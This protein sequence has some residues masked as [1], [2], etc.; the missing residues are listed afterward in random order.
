MRRFRKGTVTKEDIQNINTRYIL[1]PDV[2]SPS[3][4]HTRYACYRNVE[5]NEYNNFTRQK[6][7]EGTHIKSNY[8]SVNFPLHTCIIKAAMKYKDKRRSHIDLTI[9]NRILDE[10]DDSDIINSKQSFVD[11]SLKF[12]HNLL[13]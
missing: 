6:Y 4:T 8:I 9:K 12:I 2:Q 10:C 5:R 7:L 13:I 11:P 3:I 1:N